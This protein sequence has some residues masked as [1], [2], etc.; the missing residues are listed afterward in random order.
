MVGFELQTREAIQGLAG[1]QATEQN[2]D[3]RLGTEFLA[4]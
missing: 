3:W 4:V 2:P 1:T